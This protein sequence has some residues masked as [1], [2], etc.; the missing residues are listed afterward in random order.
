MKTKKMGII[1]SIGILIITL[2]VGSIIIK[3]N[4][5]L[6]YTKK[7]QIAVNKINKRMGEINSVLPDL[8]KQQTSEFEKNGR[9]KK[10]LKV[11]NKVD[12]L[13]AEKADLDIELDT[14]RQERVINYKGMIP[15]IILII[16]GIIS[17]ILIFVKTKK[18]KDN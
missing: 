10:Y 16:F 9:S 4:N 15:G 13:N 11:S 2:L 17:S 3:N 7:D 8:K 14:L 1:I 18:L 12:K 5:K 6:I